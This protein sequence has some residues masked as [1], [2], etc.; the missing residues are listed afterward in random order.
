M[1]AGRM[2]LMS[3]ALP[4]VPPAVSCDLPPTGALIVSGGDARIACDPLRGVN[5]YGCAPH[6][7]PAILAFGSSTASTISPAA[8]AAADH[9]RWRLLR[10]GRAG[11]SPEATYAAELARQRGE[12]LALNGL[13]AEFGVEAVFA[14]SGTDLHRIAA[15]LA[16]VD[17]R[18]LTVIMVDPAE[19]GSG[20]AAALSGRDRTRRREPPARGRELVTIPI[21]T[22]DGRPRPPAAVDDEVAVRVA[23]AV[24]AGRRVLLNPVDVSKTGLVA[25]S[26]ACVLGLMSRFPDAIEVTVDACQ[27]R[28][29]PGTLRAYLA[30]GV[31]VALT[32]SKFVGGPAF[33]GALLLPA[34]VARRAA[35][36]PLP[37]AFAGA[38][39]AEWPAGWAAQAGLVEGVNFGLLLRFEA[40]LAEM[41]A[42]G[43]LAEPEV[44][45]F[46]TDFAGAVGTRLATDPA[47][48]LLGAPA[49]DRWPLAGCGGWDTVTTIFPF[50]L[51]AGPGGR[52]L[53]AAE[54]AQVHARLALDLSDRLSPPELSA[55]RCEVGQPVACG[56]RRGVPVAAL[57]LCASMRLAVEA[58]GG[59]GRGPAAVIADALIVLDKAALLAAQMASAAPVPVVA[60]PPLAPS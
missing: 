12:L 40:A 46:F 35:R 13:S 7:D 53:T 26:V 39:K 59:Q 47:F 6:P 14:A 16:A 50:L 58:L 1:M 51:R 57:R 2:S 45:G 42:F 22:A 55:R 30:R 4:S 37:R 34:R 8:Y 21:R 27:L 28:I 43:A 19:T 31:S 56:T 52:L 48:E 18:P 23:A 11:V 5:A 9:L 41:R 44:T 17:R 29:A 25:P 20:V 33:C 32:G 3:T 60:A 15:Q 10:A 49:P 24:R 38:P 36:A 54:T